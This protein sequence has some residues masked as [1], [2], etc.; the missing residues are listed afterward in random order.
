MVGHRSSRTRQSVHTNKRLHDIGRAHASQH[1]CL[2]HEGRP[3]CDSVRRRLCRADRCH[4]VPIGLARQVEAPVEARH[5]EG[6]GAAHRPTVEVSV[7][8]SV[9][10]CLRGLVLFG[11]A[12]IGHQEALLH[13]ACCGTIKVTVVDVSWQGLR[14]SKIDDIRLSAVHRPR[15]VSLMSC[16]DDDDKHGES[17][18]PIACA[19]C[20]SGSPARLLLGEVILF[21]FPQASLG[22]P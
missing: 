10:L 21:D 17:M 2:D 5:P 15:R 8:E 4:H 22:G 18:N 12:L 13:A 20:L 1:Y 3:G 6:E 9:W 14:P 19:R 11:G 7:R 16:D